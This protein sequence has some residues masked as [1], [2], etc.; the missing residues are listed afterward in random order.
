M[1]FVDHPDI[2]GDRSRFIWIYQAYQELKNYIKSLE[3]G[4]PCVKVNASAYL[5]LVYN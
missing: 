5:I 4:N 3:S 1:I 2:A